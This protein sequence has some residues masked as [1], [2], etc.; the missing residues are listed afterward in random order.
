MEIRL[1]GNNR[2]QEA[3]TASFEQ[4]AGSHSK[5]TK[6]RHSTQSKQLRLPVA[7]FTHELEMNHNQQLKVVGK[8]RRQTSNSKFQAFS[9]IC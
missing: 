3:S 1:K 9:A 4:V 8:S 2:L 7:F 6:F 5:E